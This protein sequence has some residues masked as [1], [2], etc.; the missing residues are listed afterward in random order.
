MREDTESPSTGTPRSLHSITGT[1]V[2]FT[3][4]SRSRVKVFWLD[5]HGKQVLYSTLE[6]S[7]GRY[8]VNTY[9]THPWIAID[10]QTNVPMLLNFRNI[11]Y[12]LAPEIRQMHGGNRAEYVRREVVITPNSKS[13]K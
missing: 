12:P 10:E 3:N 11:Y 6:P 4:R 7:D 1:P 9:V 2:R 8:D 5:Y 13:L